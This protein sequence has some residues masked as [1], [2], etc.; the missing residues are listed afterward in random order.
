MAQ[1][2]V[3]AAAPGAFVPV[4]GRLEIGFN[5]AAM[6]MELANLKH[7]LAMTLVR[8]FG[9]PIADGFFIKSGG[10]GIIGS[11]AMAVIKYFAKTKH[12]L[13]FFAQTRPEIK[14]ER[15]AARSF[16][17]MLVVISKIDHGA[18][19]PCFNRLPKTR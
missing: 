13:G 17:A 18:G 11:Y 7:G 8:R 15:M 6:L 14:C 9:M 2:L 12:G 19:M 10:S 3:I 4:F 5:P 16:M 1:A